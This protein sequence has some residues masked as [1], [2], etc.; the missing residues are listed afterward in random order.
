MGEDQR[1]KILAWLHPYDFGSEQ[2]DVL[3]KAQHGTGKWLLDSSEFQQW[4][5]GEKQSLLCQGIPGAGKT[6]MTSI[7]INHLSKTYQ[8]K[9]DIK[10]SYLYCNFRRKYEQAPADLLALLLAQL[11][12]QQEELPQCLL[13]LYDFHKKKTRPSIGE[14][15]STLRVIV[16]GNR[17]VYVAIDALDEYM[18]SRGGRSKLLDH[19]FGL[20]KDCALSIFA[21]SRFTTEIEDVFKRHGAAFLEIRA[22][23]AD[24]RRYIQGN[25][26]LLLPFA[27]KDA[28]L[29]SEVEKRV[30]EA[31][32]GMYVPPGW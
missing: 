13:E 23:D 10:I 16:S 20:Q 26:S 8:N 7:I 28:T 25:V 19:I 18:L 22:K 17:R 29:T 21:T 30:I 9:P 3:R 24:I 32:D 12:W 27:V 6:V 15:S 4:L 2:S 1:S 11:A 31:A 14:I 5:K